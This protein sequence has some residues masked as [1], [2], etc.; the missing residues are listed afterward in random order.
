MTNN[1]LKRR[2]FLNN[3]G[4]K[5]YIYKHGFSLDVSSPPPLPLP[6]KK[7]KCIKACMKK[8]L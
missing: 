4:M 8:A 6:I 2:L 1:E 5:Q 7:S 3:I